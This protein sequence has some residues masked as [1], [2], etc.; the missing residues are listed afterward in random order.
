MFVAHKTKALGPENF[1]MWLLE[2][3]SVNILFI[4]SFFFPPG[5]QDSFKSPPLRP[6]S[7]RGKNKKARYNRKKMFQ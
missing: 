5:H 2:S 7:L 3:L 1:Q 6:P 4:Y